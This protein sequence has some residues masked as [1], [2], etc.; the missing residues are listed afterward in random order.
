MS[1]FDA[2]ARH[3]SLTPRQ[4][5]L[6]GSQ[7]ALDYQTLWQQIQHLADRLQQ[8]GIRRLALQLDN[9]L[10]WALIDLACTRAGIVVIPVPHFFSPA[11][12]AWLLES[13]GADALVGPEHEGWQA[14]APLILM[15]GAA[16]EQALPLWRRTPV[17]PPAL[18]L[19]T[20][21]ITYTSGTTGQPKGVCLSLAQ[22]MAVCESLAL[23]VAPAGVEQ[24]LTLLPLATLL[25]NLTGLYVPLLTGACSRIPSLGELGFT[26]SS[27]LDPAMLGQ[28]LARWPSHSLVLVPE[29]LRLLLALCANTPPLAERLKGLR[30]VAVGGGKVAPELIA[31]ARALG[32]P[33]YEGYGLSECGS[34]VALNGP[35]A[36]LMGSVGRP[37]PHCQ[38]TIAAGSDRVVSLQLDVARFNAL[39]TL[40]SGG[41]AVTIGADSQPGVYLGKDSAGKLIFKLTLDVSGRYTFELT[42]NLD[43]SVQGKDLL[44]IQLPLQARDSDGDLSAE[45]IGHVS[46]QDDVPVAVD[47]SKTLNEGAK[48]T[49]DLLATASE[50]ADD[51]VVRAVTI[52]GTEHPIA[53]TGNTTISVTDSTG[54][55]IGTLVINA[56]GDYSFTAKSGIDHSNS[57]LVQQIGFHLVDGDG[58]TDDGLLTLTIR[59]EAGKL[60]VSAVTGQ[61]D[62]G[63]SDPGQG[64]PIT[65]NLDV[66]DF[67]RGEHVEQLLIQAP[68]NA[69]GTF[70]F[71]GV[72]LTTITQGG[73]TWYEVPPAAMVAVA[74]TDDKFQ[75]TG[76]TF[77]PNHDYSS[78][79][80]GGAALRFPVQ[81]Q[82]GV[83]EGSKPPVLTGNL[84][85]TVQGIADKPLWDAGSTHQHYTT[86]EDSSGIAL[87]V[88]AGLTD[89]DGSETLSYQIKWASGQGTLTL[90]GKVLTPGAN[91]L[92]TVAGGD[93]NKVTVVPGKDYSGDIKLIVTPVSTEKTPV[94]TGKE[95][96]LG[97]PLEV[98][99]NV[100]PLADDAKLTVREIQGKEDTLIDLGSKIGLAHLGDTTDGS[101]QL[102][103]RISGL[104]A[105]ATLLLG[106]VAV[107]QDA[108]GYYEV[109]YDR[110]NDLKLLPPKN[111]NV[112]FDLT[113]KGVV[114]DTAILTDASGQTHTV[115]NEKETGSQS[116]HVDLVG[117]V[118]E[119][120]FDLNTTDWTQDGNGYSITI[121]EDG[122]APL[123][124]KLTSGEWTDTPLDHSETLNLVL[125]GRPEG[126]KVFDGNGK[127][128]TLTFA[129]LDAQGKPTYQVDVSSLGNLQIQPPPNSTADLHLIGHVVVTENDGD[130]KGFDVPLTIKVEPAIDAT[131]YAR[132]SHGL[133]DQ[134]TVLDWQPDLTDGAEQVTHLG[135]SGIAPGYE[136]WIRVGG[137]ETQLNVTGG[138]V[139]LSDTDLKSLL[140]GGQHALFDKAVQRCP[141]N[142][143]LVEL[144]RGQRA[145]LQGGDSGQLARAGL[146]LFRQRPRQ[147]VQALRRA[148]QASLH[149]VPAVHDSGP[150]L[151]AI[152][153][154]CLDGLEPGAEGALF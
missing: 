128:L 17:A 85:I 34:V 45:V 105:G 26:G 50:G 110:I 87:N 96:A 98:I 47:A 73:K 48:V 56:E 16:D 75:L 113:I 27:T 38:V 37:L 86:D 68:A 114:K 3:A 145:V 123:D 60:T 52:N 97:D 63:A 118:D 124:F 76:V 74:N 138:K 5:A 141:G 62:A 154:D 100:N 106:G 116:L 40:T 130:H 1:L 29:L 134:F 77:V 42:G 72:A 84:D 121:Q 28:A 65:M 13:S 107:T 18:P 39:N 66:G 58:D 127:E 6:Q 41:K 89:T 147:R 35:D 137:A 152:R 71:N 78:Y 109:P 122:R 99:V 54:Q 151:C 64:I 12:Q 149:D 136:I 104:P 70:Y 55:I 125:E 146:W 57:T 80:N 144:P 101:E 108:N 150:V 30:F 90:N 67:D 53:A 129:G 132:T 93:I 24:H 31:H 112:D 9:G 33:V 8:A 94:V 133:E 92:Y 20:A 81:L 21:K 95:T 148:G 111:S 49:G 10:P 4:P 61:E 82:V 69:Q 46:V 131:D 19:G 43:H 32:L 44:D 7:G 120:H 142:T 119:P 11:Q 59:D 51:A 153:D 102:F 22:M 25:E 135:L 126:A 143:D 79:N 14:A 15:T 83:T 103:V 88:K 117:V 91:G 23:R 2:I 115:V 140:G 36:D 139:E